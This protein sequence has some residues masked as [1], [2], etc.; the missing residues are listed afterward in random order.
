MR[1]FL[2]FVCYVFTGGVYASLLQL[3]NFVYCYRDPS[4]CPE[5]DMYHL[6]MRIIAGV[7]GLFFAIFTAAMFFDQYEGMTTNTTG[8][9]AMKGWAEEDRSLSEGMADACGYPFGWKW[10]FPI[11]LGEDSPSMYRWTPADDKDAVDKRD[12]AYQRHMRRVD[13]V[14]REQQAQ[15][16]QRPAGGPVVEGMTPEQLRQLYWGPAGNGA[17]HD[18]GHGHGH[19]VDGSGGGSLAVGPTDVD[20]PA[21][22]PSV[23]CARPLNPMHTHAA[24]AIGVPAA[25]AAPASGTPAGAR[26][27]GTGGGGG[28]EGRA[29]TTGVASGGGGSG[30]KARKK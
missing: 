25:A 8:I 7:L 26:S 20:T 4:L 13:A 23:N 2:Q 5:P 30:A 28:G 3:A 6:V 10:F 1:F 21:I 27:A 16:P 19:G 17:G 18:H 15:Q 9:E 14:L 12:P 29:L 24:A 11:T 22:E